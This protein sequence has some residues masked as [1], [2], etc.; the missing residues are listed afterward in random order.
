[1]QN[2]YVRGLYTGSKKEIYGRVLDGL[3]LYNGIIKC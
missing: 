2:L 1:M 3:P